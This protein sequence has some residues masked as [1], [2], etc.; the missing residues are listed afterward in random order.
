[1]RIETLAVGDELLSGSTQDT[2]SR[3][4][5]RELATLGLR[6]ERMTCASDDA[7]LLRRAVEEALG[8]CD[9]LLVTG[10]LGP[11]P[12]D[13]TKEI[14]AEILADDLELDPLVLEDIRRRFVAR[15]RSMPEINR[16][17]ALRPRGGRWIPNPV[18][19]APGVHWTSGGREIFL[20]PGVPAEMQ[21]M[22][23]DTVLPFLG[24]SVPP[25][26]VLRATFRTCG[27]PE[28]E[29]AERLRALVDAHPEV[30][31]AFY[32]SWGLVDVQVRG[33]AAASGRWAELCAGIRAVASHFL[34]SEDASVPLAE[35]VRRALA[36]AG[37]TLAVAESCTGGL[38]GA[39]MTEVAGASA[40]FLG[41]F[42]T[43][44]NAAK[45][46]WLG[47]PPGLLQTH[48][49]VSAEVATAMA[50]GARLRAAADIAVA[51]TGI[52]GPTGGTAEKP[53]GLVFLAL[54]AAAGTWTRRLSLG[55]HRD[56]NRAVASHLA[57]D[58]VRR[59]LA[60]LPVGD[61]A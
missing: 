52:A 36:D 50:R 54:D 25:G 31:W 33:V 43:Y 20:L 58:L 10:G 19:S 24:R 57:L 51:V 2:N 34:Y 39:R 30:E 35:V 55:P 49:A 12:D 44:S 1:V 29:L 45:T 60:G 16:K 23:R 22:L 59:H 37:A 56:M 26:S 46:A 18:G 28:S 48:G 15:G 38:V 14:V 21:A 17:Q 47:V 3:F 27:I 61:P 42:V 40:C 6:L 13:R 5:A 4:V 41:G 53:V 9:V 32:P 8:R 7:A 11:T